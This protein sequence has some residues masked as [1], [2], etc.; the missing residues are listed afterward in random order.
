[1]CEHH[2]HHRQI[3]DEKFL[4]GIAIFGA[5]CLGEYFEAL[6]VFVLYNLGEFLQ[7][8][9]VEKSKKSISE[10][11]DLRPDSAN[12]L[13]GSEIVAKSPENVCVGDIIV[14]KTGEKIALD[15]VVSDG[16]A[17]LDTSALT[18][19]ALPRE[20]KTNDEV[21]SGCVVTNGV[22]KIKVTKTFEQS[23]V[24]QILEL[25]EHSGAKKSKTENF[26][27]KFARIYTPIVILLALLIAFIPPLFLH[28][29]FSEWIKRALTL[30]VISCPCALVISVPLGFFAGLGEASRNG[31][32]IKGSKYIE[33]LAKAETVV[34]DKT[35]TLTKG[36]FT[37]EEVVSINGED[38]LKL[39]A[40]V[41]KYSNHPI[42]KSIRYDGELFEVSDVSEIAGYGIKAKIGDDEIFVGKNGE[43]A[44]S[45]LKNDVLIGYITLSDELKSNAEKTILELKNTVM[46]SGDT[47]E[48]VQKFAKKLGI[49][50]AF[51][52]LL[53]QDKVKKLE[54]IIANSSGTVLFVGDGIND[55]PALRLADVGISMG[56]LGSDSAIEASDVVIMNDAPY[57]VVTGIKIAQKTLNIVKQNIAF[58]ISVKVIF[59]LLGTFGFMTMWGAIFADV[60]VT[61]LAV[62]NS[63]RAMKR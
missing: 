15:G 2:H 52:K 50:H 6:A 23:A 48:N 46:L 60:G 56:G 45:V 22:L 27:T 57:K 12:V 20:V 54:E 63:L 28:A 26:I 14:V 38:I 58:A 5:I 49:T 32:L 8:K 62:L 35:G 51:S 24:S 1:M 10:L 18:G 59:L 40:S 4:M 25:V 61:L 53:P 17:F 3:F 7:D 43:N 19:E 47:D 13:V 21:L 16:F 9:A 30:L 31:I 33:A 42:A 37:V 36:N 44:V 29:G 11:M 39:A 55:A 34:F 41:E